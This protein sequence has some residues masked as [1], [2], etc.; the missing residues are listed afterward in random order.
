MIRIPA[1]G[2]RTTSAERTCSIPH[3]AGRNRMEKIARPGFRKGHLFLL[4]SKRTKPA[5]RSNAPAVPAPRGTCQAKKC[6]GA[7]P[8]AL[9]SAARRVRIRDERGQRCARMI[10]QGAE[11]VK[12]KNV[13]AAREPP[14]CPTACQTTL[15]PT[16]N[17]AFPTKNSAF[18]TGKFGAD[19]VP[20]D[21]WRYSRNGVTSAHDP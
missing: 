18:A 1:R 11:R 4:F 6:R 14:C 5:A 20:S 17:R 21:A 8:C 2:V 13:G 19:V 15:L 9:S 3:A 7:W 10:P 12:R 16:K